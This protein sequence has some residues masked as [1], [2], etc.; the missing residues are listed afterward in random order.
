MPMPEGLL[1]V[2]NMPVKHTAM[3][4]TFSTYENMNKPPQAPVSMPPQSVKIGD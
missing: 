4:G 3:K 2:D 1:P